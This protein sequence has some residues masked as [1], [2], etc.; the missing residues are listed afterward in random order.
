MSI[1]A[2]PTTAAYLKAGFLG[3][4]GSGK[5]Y[6]AMMLAVKMAKLTK[7]KEIYFLDTEGGSDYLIHRVKKADCELLVAKTRAFTDLLETVNNSDIKIL[8]I[9]SITHYWQE[10]QETYL[11]E[12]Q[13]AANNR[14]AKWGKKAYKQEL[15]FQDWAYL[16]SQWAKFTT[17]YLNSSIHIVMCGRLG[18]EWSFQENEKGKKEL[19]KD[20]IKMKAEG[21]TGYEPSLLVHMERISSAEHPEKAERMA[22][23]LKDRFGVLDGH[24]CVNPKP[25]FFMPHIKLLSKSTDEHKAFDD[26]R[27]STELVEKEVSGYHENTS[28]KLQ[29]MILDQIKADLEAVHAGSSTAAKEIRGKILIQIFGTASYEMIGVKSKDELREGYNKMVKLIKLDELKKG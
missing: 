21:E 15:Q 3:L 1:F 11:K 10:L 14:S 2:K 4:A 23:V 27:K 19:I 13:E 12:K 24:K 16:K 8:V 9:D 7:I 29:S 25:D 22:T 28:K 5:T 20:D 6:T 26:T 17:G 18:Y